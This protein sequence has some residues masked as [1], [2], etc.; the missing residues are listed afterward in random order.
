LEPIKASQPFFVVE[1]KMSKIWLRTRRVINTFQNTNM[2]ELFVK[3]PFW[4]TIRKFV[5]TFV[6][7]KRHFSHFLKMKLDWQC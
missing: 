2:L 5:V 6:L 1:T 7:L 4:V 3:G